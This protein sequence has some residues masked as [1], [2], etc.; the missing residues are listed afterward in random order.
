[1]LALRVI[2]C[3]DPMM[4]YQDLVG[5]IVPFV[6]DDGFSFWSRERCGFINT[7]QYCDAELV[8]IT[9]HETVQ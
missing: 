4:W 5:E 2:N 1:M 7:V 6:N 8:D 9:E 3:S